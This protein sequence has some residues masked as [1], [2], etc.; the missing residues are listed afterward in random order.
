MGVFKVLVDEAEVG[1]VV[2]EGAEA[3]AGT[4][5]LA[6][7]FSGE[8]LGMC[9]QRRAIFAGDIASK[10]Q[11]N[12]LTPDLSSLLGAVVSMDFGVLVVV[13]ILEEVLLDLDFLL[14]FLVLNLHFLLLLR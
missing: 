6:S 12:E 10:P 2:G 1:A 14:L 3:E 7:I 5:K 11:L 4:L 8:L 13:I 9:S